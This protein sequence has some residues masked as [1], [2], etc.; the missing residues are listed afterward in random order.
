ARLMAKL[1]FMDRII[2]ALGPEY[3]DNL[4]Q[5]PS[6]TL[7]TVPTP[8]NITAEP[9]PYRYK[10][11]SSETFFP[12]CDIPQNTDPETW[13]MRFNLYFDLSKD[14]EKLDIINATLRLYKN[15]SI[16]LVNPKNLL[17]KA[18]EYGRYVPKRRRSKKTLI[19]TKSV[20]SDYIGW[21]SLHIEKTVKRWRKPRNNHGIQISVVDTDTI[22]WQAEN[23]FVI[24]NCSS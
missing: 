7:A 19:A 10:R 16:P 17:I 15:N 13:A 1:S 24:M 21:V 14:L 8:I 22:P 2:K 5:P 6:D 3:V 11:C 23:I 4:P 20:P 12:S 9:C 18:H